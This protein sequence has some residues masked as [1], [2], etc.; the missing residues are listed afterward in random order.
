[1]SDRTTLETIAQLVPRGARVLDL[2]CGDGELL[3]HLQAKRGC[4]GY[5]VEIADANVLACLK[6]GVN[7]IQLNLDEGLAMFDDASFDVVLQIDTLQ[8]LRNTEVMLRETAR[9]GRTGIVAFPNFGHWPNRFSILR[10]RMPVTR[11]LPY[12]WYDTPNIRVTTF[13]DFE[14]LALRSGLKIQESFGLHGDRVVRS[15]PNLMASTAVFKF[16]R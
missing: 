12:Q 1:M 2:G 4:S 7:V 6:R 10:G 5:G 8:H 11:R 16:T 9:V 14:V 13:M 3:A 15:L